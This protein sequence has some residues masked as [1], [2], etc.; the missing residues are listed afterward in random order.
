[1]TWT[2]LSDDYAD[3]A[4]LNSV[5][6]SARHLNTEAL[7]WCNKHLTDG[8]LPAHMLRRITDADDPNA[9]ATELVNAGFWTKTADGW[10]VDWA[11]QQTAAEVKAERLRKA[12]NKA[13]YDAR[14]ALHNKGD[15]STCTKSCPFVTG[16]EPIQN[17]LRTAS[18]PVPL[19]REKGQAGQTRPASGANAPTAS[20]P[21]RQ[22]YGFDI[23]AYMKQAD[24][25][26]K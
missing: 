10:D 19:K 13:D 12:K 14:G 9:D 15:H 7:C 21:P 6:R 3:D 25:A 20:E 26:Q 1:M 4:Q 17:R 23:A 11:D 18:R 16:S 24:G 2:R 5:S 22:G 8:A